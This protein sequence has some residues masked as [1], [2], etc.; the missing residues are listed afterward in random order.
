[1]LDVFHFFFEDDHRYQTP[2]EAKG[3]EAIRAA[4]Y[5]TMYRKNY[6]YKVS[7]S[8]NNNTS[9]FAYNSNETKPYIPPT[10]FDP[11]VGLIFGNNVESP[12]R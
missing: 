12:L 10:E 7:G 9:G 11:E 1:M 3:V 8:V 5:E 2:E 4:I 6:K